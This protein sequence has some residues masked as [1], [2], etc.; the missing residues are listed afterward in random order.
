MGRGCGQP[1]PAVAP[2]GYPPDSGAPGSPGGAPARPGSPGEAPRPGSAGGVPAGPVCHGAPAGG[3]SFTGCVSVR[4]WSW[5]RRTGGADLAGAGR[6]GAEAGGAARAGGPDGGPAGQGERWMRLAVVD[7]EDAR[8]WVTAGWTG[9]P[10]PGRR[11]ATWSGGG[12]SRAGRPSPSS[13]SRTPMCRVSGPCGA[14]WPRPGTP[15][16]WS[17]ATTSRHP[18][19]LPQHRLLRPGRL[20]GGGGRPYLLLHPGR[21]AQP[22]PG[23]AAGRA[24][25]GPRRP[26]TRSAIPGP[27]GPGGARS[28]LAWPARGTCARR[29]EPGRRPRPWASARAGPSRRPHRRRG[30]WAGSW[31]S[32][33]TRPTTASTRSGPHGGPAPTW[34]SPAGCGSPPP[35]T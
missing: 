9:W 3:L 29:P 15:G 33:W 22:G 4:P 24:D 14:S 28:W 10:W 32:C 31:T 11:P 18:R 16:G 25:P 1:C 8:F 23:G 7:T 27:P 35:S 5:R 26:T 34:C 12:W 13:T 21:A 19:G 2:L 30:S 6:H 20:R 17:G